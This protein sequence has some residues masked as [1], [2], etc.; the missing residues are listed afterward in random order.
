MLLQDIDVKYSVRYCTSVPAWIANVKGGIIVKSLAKLCHK[1]PFN[2]DG[3]RLCF[4]YQCSH[5][6]SH[7]QVQ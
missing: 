4:S 5:C 6:A 3:L 7:S 2:E 1:S